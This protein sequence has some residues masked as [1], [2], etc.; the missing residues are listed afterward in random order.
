MSYLVEISQPAEDDFHAIYSYIA[1]RS[2]EG[3][4]RWK[5]AFEQAIE[6]LETMPLACSLAAEN[7]DHDAEIR[8]FAFNTRSGVVYRG[9]IT[10][11][12]QTVHI[13]HIRGSG[14]NP[15]TQDELQLPH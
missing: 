15:M 10:I 3:A 2:A 11:V 5:E 14:Q 1:A 7:D 13:L 12:E 8:Q 6:S 9:L 4:V